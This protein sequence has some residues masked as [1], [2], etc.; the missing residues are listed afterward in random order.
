MKKL[1]I[2]LSLIP[3]LLWG[4][5]FES[6]RMEDVIPHVGEETWVFLDVDNTLIESSQHLGSAQWRNHIL[7]KAHEAGYR[8][9]EQELVLDKFWFFVQQF[10]PMRLVDPYTVGVI[11]QLAESN[12][13]I[14]ALTARE[15]IESGYTQR[16]LNSVGISLPSASRSAILLANEPALLDQGV[17]YCGENTKSEGVIAFFEEMGRIPKKMVVVDDR[18]DQL[19]ALEETAQTLGIEFVGIRFSAADRR[20]QSFDG[21]IADVQFSYLP[22]VVSDEDANEMLHG[23]IDLYEPEE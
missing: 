11:E 9:E 10:I 2:S 18:L 5:I 14:F 12:D 3:S 17:I 21:D 22:K 4:S 16:Q 19:K 1:F 6:G 7:K 15:P 8:N 20:V 13:Y 23:F